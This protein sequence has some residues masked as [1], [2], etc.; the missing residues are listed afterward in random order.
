[1]I[2]RAVDAQ[3]DWM[4]GKGR[5]DYKTGKYAL[6]QNLSTRLN[7]YLGDCFFAI[8][9]GLDW[10]NLLGSK[11]QLALEFAV[12]ALILNT[13]NVTGIV[14]LDINLDSIS[15]RITMTYVLNSVFTNADDSGQ[16]VGQTFLLITESGDVLTTESGEAI[17][18]G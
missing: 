2:V 9:E 3:N 11:N 13:E 15:R 4:F 5:N 14:S 6:E 1:M 16:V 17:T 10:F 18:T 7:S 8:S 12:R